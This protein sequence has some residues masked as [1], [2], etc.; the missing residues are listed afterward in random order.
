[1]SQFTLHASTKKGNRPSYIRASKPEMAIAAE[2]LILGIKNT[3]KDRQHACSHTKSN[4]GFC[5]SRRN[6]YRTN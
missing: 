1:M 2:P 4:Q 5:Y 6:N 3:T